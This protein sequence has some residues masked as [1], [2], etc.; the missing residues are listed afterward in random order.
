MDTPNLGSYEASWEVVTPVSKTSNH[1]EW[2]LSNYC[3]IF[4][5][6][7]RKEEDYDEDVEESLLEEVREIFLI[8]YTFYVS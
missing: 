4:I 8:F 2:L 1:G 3:F 6:E 7:K 5:L